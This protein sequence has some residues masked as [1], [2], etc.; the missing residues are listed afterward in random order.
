MG[1]TTHMFDSK[2]KKPEIS[3]AWL[4]DTFSGCADF[5]CRPVLPGLEK[6]PGLYACWVDGLADGTAIAEDILRP[7]T[8]AARMA[9]L[10]E[11]RLLELLELGVI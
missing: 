4:R 7:L 9:P 3:M 6:T 8:D 10:T 1:H 2:T 5:E 11:R